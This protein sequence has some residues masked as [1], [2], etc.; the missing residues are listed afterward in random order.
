MGLRRPLP[1]CM[2]ATA[3]LAQMRAGCPTVGYRR[4]LVDTPVATC[5]RGVEHIVSSNPSPDQAVCCGQGLNGKQHGV[6]GNGKV[7]LATAQGVQ[8]GLKG[9]EALRVTVTGPQL[10]KVEDLGLQDPC[11]VGHMTECAVSR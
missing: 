7:A 6:S 1:I 10:A 3:K 5:T 4:G 8:A 11:D 9:Q 2:R